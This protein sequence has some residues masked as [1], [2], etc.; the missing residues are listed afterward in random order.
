VGFWNIA[1]GEIDPASAK[2]IDF[3]PQLLRWA[4]F[5][6][7]LDPMK[8]FPLPPLSAKDLQRPIFEPLLEHD[9]LTCALL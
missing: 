7:S 4:L 1:E 9:A 2:A 8:Q 6:H 5:F 3:G